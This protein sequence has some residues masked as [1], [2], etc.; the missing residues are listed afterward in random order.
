MTSCIRIFKVIFVRKVS[1]GLL[2]DL[3][4]ILKKSLDGF[5][6]EFFEGVLEKFPKISNVISGGILGTHGN[7]RKS[8]HKGNFL[9]E[10][11]GKFSKQIS[12]GNF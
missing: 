5:L 10:T 7:I 4:E 3:Y 8:V 12:E 9:E 1:V 2:E 11:P 6:T